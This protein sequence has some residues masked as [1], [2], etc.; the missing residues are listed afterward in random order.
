[1][2]LDESVTSIRRREKPGI[3]SAHSSEAQNEI[4][5]EF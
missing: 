5:G 2:M 1:M 4:Q 3:N